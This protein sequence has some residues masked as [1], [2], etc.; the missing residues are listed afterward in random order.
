VRDLRVFPSTDLIGGDAVSLLSRSAR[1]RALIRGA[2]TLLDI[3]GSSLRYQKSSNEID[4]SASWRAVDKALHQAILQFDE[5]TRLSL[6]EALRQGSPLDPYLRALEIGGRL[7]E[8][9]RHLQNVLVLETSF[10][11]V[12]PVRDIQQWDRIWRERLSE[13]QQDSSRAGEL[14][15]TTLR[16]KIARIIAE[17]LTSREFLR[18]LLRFYQK[19]ESIL[20]AASAAKNDD[21]GDHKG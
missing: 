21:P 2:A 19:C 7:D 5:S 18:E 12:A 15:L 1:R 11:T 3:A 14:I 6:S 13:L 8:V 10:Y 4:A 20:L 9:L 17:Q 16:T